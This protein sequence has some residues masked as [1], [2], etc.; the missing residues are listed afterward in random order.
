ML[1]DKTCSKQRD[2]KSRGFAERNRYTQREIRKII[3]I[4]AEAVSRTSHVSMVRETV[5]A[6]F[7]TRCGAPIEFLMLLCRWQTGWLSSLQL[8]QD[9]KCQ[10]ASHLGPSLGLS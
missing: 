2:M 1:N 9:T 7:E 8:A 6:C 3:Y 5:L 10:P 4:R